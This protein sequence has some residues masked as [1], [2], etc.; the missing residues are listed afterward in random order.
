MR[1]LFLTA[2]L[3]GDGS[4]DSTDGRLMKWTTPVRLAS[5]ASSQDKSE[6]QASMGEAVKRMHRL[7][8]LAGADFRPSKGGDDDVVN[9]ILLVSSDFRSDRDTVFAGVLAE[10]FNGRLDIYDQLADGAS[11]ICQGQIFATQD[12]VISGG[13]SLVESDIEADAFDRCL[14][15]VV[16]KQ[17]GL[18]H[19]LPQDVDSVLSP[20]SQRTTWTSIDFF[21][22]K[23][24]TDPAI[25]PGMGAA[26]LWS[27]L[28]EIH[29]RALHPSS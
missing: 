15:Q 7:A 17:L 25:V 22:L 20:N 12:A 4:S 18:R 28:P 3:G 23:M 2:T 26:E 27:L 5:L 16:L 14:H 1:S 29:R 10:I 9:F 21:L 24:L 19:L 8:A 13:L 6:L 11:P